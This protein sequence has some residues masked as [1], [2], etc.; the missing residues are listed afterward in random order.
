MNDVDF[1]R[2]LDRLSA[3]SC[4]DRHEPA[5]FT[6]PE[7][8]ADEWCFSPELVSL[9]ATPQWQAMS[10]SQQKRLAFC[11]AINFFSLN[12][13]G[14][15]YLI[16]EIAKRLYDGGS[17]ALSRYLNHFVTEESVH[18]QYFAGFCE[19]YGDGLYPDRSVALDEPAD[20][21]LDGLLLFAR[22]NLFE[23]IVDHYNA[24]MARDS[25][26]APVVRE[27][28]RIHHREELRHLAFGRR[29]LQRRVALLG[30]E[31][32]GNRLEAMAAA[33]ASYRDFVWSQYYS[34]D[35]YR[36]A[37]LD[38]PPALRRAALQSVTARRHRESVE[39]RRL[40][41]LRGLGLQ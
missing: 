3:L 34:V 29:Y 33:L 7:R 30:K 35:A 36:G 14:E 20:V 21:D 39:R 40:G 31:K 1:D 4:S 15:R 10:E 37:A 32:R 16:A 28:H 23:E 5:D 6:W 8:L 2:F 27:I 18:M 19:R 11:E 25:R 24:V 17:A 22:I 9:Y 38:N 41:F 12:V 26:L 13:H